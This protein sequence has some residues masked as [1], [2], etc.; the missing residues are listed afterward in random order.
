MIL[1]HPCWYPAAEKES[2]RRPVLG[3]HDQSSRLQGND[4]R[5]DQCLV[6]SQTRGCSQAAGRNWALQKQPFLVYSQPTSHS[7]YWTLFFFPFNVTKFWN[8]R[9]GYRDKSWCC[10]SYS[11]ISPWLLCFLNFWHDKNTTDTMVKH[12]IDKTKS[13]DEWFYFPLYQKT[14]INVE[15]TA[16]NKAYCL[17]P[18]SPPLFSIILRR[19]IR[20]SLCLK[21]FLLM[22]CVSE[23][24]NQPR[25]NIFGFQLVYYTSRD[26]WS[27]MD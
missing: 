3:C 14:V 7:E 25:T 8:C 15:Q 27:I 24:K 18:P 5:G 6:L 21:I 17:R 19:W 12:L 4:S 1:G 2:S 10:S 23:E 20:G 13:S 22:I 26:L 11:S 16:F 9:N